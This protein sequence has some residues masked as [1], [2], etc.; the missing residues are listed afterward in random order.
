MSESETDP[1]PPSPT[2]GR[3]CT[4]NVRMAAVFISAVVL[5][6]F[7][8]RMTGYPLLGR[9]DARVSSYVLDAVQNGNWIVQKEYGGE[10]AAKPPLLTWCAAV[11]T[12][13]TGRISRVAIHLPAAAALCA[14]ALVLLVAGRNRYGWRAGFLAA[15]AYVVS[16]AGYSQ[17]STARYDGLLALMVILS[18][19]A[20]FRAWSNGSG[21]TWFWLA[22]AAGTMV[23]GPLAV[24]LGAAGLLAYFWEWRTGSRAPLR[25][26]HF[27]G[28]LLF[29]LIGGGWFLLAYAQL[30]QP[31][32]HKVIGR[33]LIGEAI[34]IDEG[35]A[36]WGP[37]KPPKDFLLTFAPWSL[38]LL[39]S[40][41]RIWK[42]PDADPTNRRFERFLVCGLL[43]GM[44]VFCSAG[45]RQSRL[46]VP[47][48]PFAALL[49]GRELAALL[50]PWSDRKLLR[51]AGLVATLFGI[52]ILVHAHFL[53]RLRSRVK[54]TLA[55]QQAARLIGER[56]GSDA[57]LTYVESSFNVQFY[58]N[59]VRP[60]VSFER[61]ATLLRGDATAWVV[62]CDVAGL[63]KQLGPDADRLYE[64]LRWPV[65]GKPLIQV[66]GNRPLPVTNQPVA[67]LLG[68]LRVEL[69]SFRLE[70]PRIN[71]RYGIE[72]SLRGS[73]AQGRLR[74]ENQGS[75][76][77]RVRIRLLDA[78][79]GE[80]GVPTERSLSPGA[81]WEFPNDSAR[82][83]VGGA[84]RLNFAIMPGTRSEPPAV[85]PVV[86]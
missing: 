83:S 70:R 26:N 13:L 49:S 4:N 66:L 25:G 52:G 72:L 21:W 50:V 20:A 60:V 16:P 42:R 34:G 15:F 6:L 77:Q 85:W 44:I 38:V 61:A 55:A 30:G 67:L 71:Y 86:P 41:W 8:I 78:K 81:V 80:A 5:V 9:H 62:V 69:Q 3:L 79:S 82:A 22:A 23:K 24:L 31:L 7:I 73:P 65:A 27:L 76:P 36:S 29:L 19:L 75:S 17:L 59:Y 46:I 84:D 54:E 1:L 40:F 33:E 74:V 53:L 64:V 14:A 48:F 51:L 63:Q 28:V 47:L 43:V 37:L 10:I 58:L 35:A 39:Y 2:P 57:P 45:H 32:I 11:P 56:L 18:A 68:P 12:L